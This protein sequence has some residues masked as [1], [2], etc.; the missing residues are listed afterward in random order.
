VTIE[1]REN[2]GRERNKYITSKYNKRSSTLMRTIL[3]QEQEVELK[4]KEV[5]LALLTEDNA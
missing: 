2:T 5:E 4:Q 1:K 3:D